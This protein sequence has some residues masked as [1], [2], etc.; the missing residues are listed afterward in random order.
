MTEIAGPVIG[1]L[2]LLVSLVA[3]MYLFHDDGDK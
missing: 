3:I 2:A 1:A